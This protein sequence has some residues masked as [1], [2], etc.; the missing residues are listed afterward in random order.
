MSFSQDVKE[1]LEKINNNARHC[2]AAEMASYVLNLGEVRQANESFFLVLKTEREGVAT[3]IENLCKK[4]YGEKPDREDRETSKGKI[5]RLCIKDGKLT[6]NVLQS[7]KMWPI[8]VNQ[9]GEPRLP[10]DRCVS[11]LLIKNSCCKRAFL[12]GSFLCI[13]SMSSPDKSYHLELVSS[14]K[15][16]LEQLNSIVGSFGIEAKFT[17][18]KGQN[19]L[20]LK[21]G[22]AIVDLLNI[23]GAHVSLMNMENVIILKDM[24]NLYNRR[25]NCETANII[26]SVN[27]ASRQVE[28]IKYLK[29]HNHFEALPEALKQMGEVRLNNPDVPLKDLG[30]L[31]DP[32]VG[33]SGVNHRLRRLSELAE[34]Y[35]Q[36]ETL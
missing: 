17:T 34:E 27:A 35:R 36:K 26:K 18:R 24:R 30:N 11:D 2:Q 25:V 4:M 3:K 9:S 21:E 28:D 20:Y 5:Y 19:V 31:L 7:V 1:E 23:M 16:Q 8:M 33:K 29:S 12:M 6:Q 10:E 13:G 22:N 32:P 15:A 14:T